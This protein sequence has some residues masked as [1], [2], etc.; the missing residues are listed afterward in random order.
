MI[1]EI[2]VIN[3]VIISDHKPLSVTMNCKVLATH[4]ADAC[5]NSDL[6]LPMWNTCD[7]FI[8]S[9]YADYL[10]KL[11]QQ[12]HLPFVA[13][14]G[15][16]CPVLIDQFY[17]DIL[18]CISKATGDCIPSRQHCNND[19]NVPGWNTYVCEKHEAAREAY[20]CWLDARKPKFGLYF[21]RMKRSRATFKLALR[22]CKNHVEELKADACAESLFHKDPRKFWNSVY[23]LSNSKA[24][25]HVNS[26]GGAS[27][28]GN[29][30]NMWKDHFQKLYS[31]NTDNKHIKNFQDKIL[32]SA[33]RSANMP[34]LKVDDIVYAISNQ[35]L[36]KAAGP[37]GICTE[38]FIYGGHRLQLYL[39]FLFNMF[40][41]H[42]YV[43]EAFC[44]STIIPLLKCKSGDL[45][46]VNNY[47]AIA[48]SNSISKI[49]EY[50]LFAF[51]D[52]SD[53][54]D[55]YQFGFRKNHSTAICT[56][57]F[58][59]TVN[60]YRQNGSHV[61]ACFIDFNKAFDNVDFWLLFCKLIDS[62][63]SCAC[64][65]ATRLLAFWYSRQLMCVRWQNMC[66]AFFSVDKGVR[67]GGI[68]SPFLF[69]FYI[70]DLITCIT[71]MSIG[72]NFGYTKVNLL[73]YA[74]DLVLLAPSWNALQTLIDA[75]AFAA[76]K[77]SMT[78]NTKKTVCMVFNPSSR[79]KLVAESFPAFT[80]CN[81]PLLFVNQ[82]KYLGHI[83]DN[84]F[85]DDRDIAREI[86]A[87]FTR[88]NVLCRRFKRCTCLVKLRLFRTFCLCLY[89]TALWTNF[90]SGT[91]NRLASCYSKCLKSFFGYPK[92]SSVTM[93][94]FE[95]G[96]PSF[97][98]V[99]H[100][101]AV[102]FTSRLAACD[103]VLV[104]C[105]SRLSM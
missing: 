16:Y 13:L 95:L 88:T 87:L 29:V 70:R 104:S 50:L 90:S 46:D 30:T 53:P 4:S 17:N 103:N 100:N 1:T 54:S 5:I 48:L 40:L 78:F 44:Q 24:T 75:A 82:F 99:I 61:F 94:L 26:I 79:G 43:P 85:S 9:Y 69:R 51:I 41:L 25:C 86:K 60:Y 11:L 74:D 45:S 39:C 38:A 23:K 62:N 96:L 71:S 65:N 66:S 32:A 35:K 72:C 91:F 6:R 98:T 20:L 34:L 10:D 73:A 63:D 83:I 21:D 57:V 33:N 89:D 92:Y 3:D 80:V 47:R 97:S 84:S 19:F 22:Y 31:D 52:S 49:L 14:N 18:S 15:N 77:I 93:M 105:V 76:S 64:F 2:N 102:S 81:C 8:L 36:G 67:Q 58:K 28:A 56:H 37:D 12:V 42:G 101:C 55:H 59:K 7:Q 68:L 27:G